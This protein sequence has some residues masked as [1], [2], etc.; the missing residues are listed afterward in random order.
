MKKIEKILGIAI[1]TLMVIRLFIAFPYNS[2]LIVL[3]TLL[4]TCIY[5]ALSFAL[6]N[7]IP[8][9]KMFTRESYKEVSTWRLIGAIGTG[10]ALSIAIVGILFVFQSWPYGYINLQNGL[11]LLGIILIV[12]VLKKG[13]SFH[14][15]YTYLLLRIGIVGF[16]GLLL[17]YTPAETLFEIK[18]HD[19]PASF[20]EAEKAY[21][22]DPNNRELEE[23]AY[24]ER[25]KMDRAAEEEKRE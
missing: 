4:L 15:F 17:L 22:K 18:C 7:G 11:I 10:W 1:I 13:V 20:I 8:F 16:I 25:I 2:M 14:Q 19:C 9:R 21:L 6:L 12:I 24:E 5:S 23:K 3:L